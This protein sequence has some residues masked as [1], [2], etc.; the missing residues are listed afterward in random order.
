MGFGSAG[1]SLGVDAGLNVV[2]EFWPEI[3]HPHRHANA[4][5]A[6]VATPAAIADDTAA[7]EAA[8]VVVLDQNGKALEAEPQQ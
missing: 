8:E 6:S 1:I 2:R 4:A 5:A 3:R 7:V